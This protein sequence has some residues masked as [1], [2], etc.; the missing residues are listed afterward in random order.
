MY[1]FTI[2]DLRT[3]TVPNFRTLLAAWRLRPYAGL[4]F[5]VTKP[6]TEAQR[7]RLPRAL[8]DRV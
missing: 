3:I 6:L 2:Q 5:I 7:K 4:R 8:R 1:Y